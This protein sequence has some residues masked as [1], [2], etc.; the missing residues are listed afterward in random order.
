MTEHNDPGSGDNNRGSRKN[1][2]SGF[3]QSKKGRW[4]IG[5]L[6]VLLLI[7]GI[8]IFRVAR[9]ITG[10]GDKIYEDV[11]REQLRDQDVSLKNGDPISILLVGIDNGALFYEDVEEGRTDVMMVLTINPEDNSS[12]IV[13]V[14]RDT[15]GPQGSTNEFDKLNHAYMNGGMEATI[16][17]IQQYL[18]IPI[19]HYVEVNMQGF[20]DV[21]DGLG[22]VELT[23]SLTFEQ[24]GANFVAGQTRTFNGEEAIHYA[25]MRKQDPEGDIGRQKRQQEVVEA[26]IDEVFSLETIT[27]YDDILNKLEDNVKTDLTVG[28]MID[29]QGNYM[30]ALGD[31]NS[32]VI[33][34]Y[35]DLNLSYG[36][37]MFVPEAERIEMSNHLRK[38]L[39]LE[40][41]NSA[42]VYPVSFGVE[43]E[44]FPVVDLNW[45]GYLEDTEM[46][47]LPGVYDQDEL[48]T[49]IDEV[50]NGGEVESEPVEEEPT[51]YDY[52]APET[53]VYES[54]VVPTDEE[55]YVPET[56]RSEAETD[57]PEPGYEEYSEEV[58]DPYAES[59]PVYSEPVVEEA[60]VPEV[61]DPGTSAIDSIY[62]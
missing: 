46:A 61:S 30:D 16:A 57:I 9:D 58:V 51:Y 8:F 25:R 5:I 55:S 12:T 7:L 14:P 39:G 62:N 1:K 43:S 21:I 10:F 11:Q 13:S 23:P 36:Y 18:D 47:I 40:S 35:V 20:I 22:G 3:W 53:D 48:D 4:S 2:K 54:E 42:I 59:E 32:Y 33:E 37:Y 31:L 52:Q 45:N 6:V 24:D 38:Q 26:V 41:T 29:L 27:N 34:D 56:Y 28:N 49:L 19:D 50:Y 17:S 44:Y 60:P 15:L